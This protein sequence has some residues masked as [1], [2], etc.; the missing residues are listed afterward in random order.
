M[1]LAT[2]LL[3]QAKAHA[4]IDSDDE[5]D[6]LTQMLATALA[7]VLAAANVTAPSTLAELPDD[8]AFAVCDQAAMLYDARG[9]A[10]E[11]ERPLGLSMAASRICARYRGVSLGA[12]EAIE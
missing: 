12:T 6:T 7:D 1:T 5:D 2:E 8:L 11:R 10:T 4:R 3:S 9:G